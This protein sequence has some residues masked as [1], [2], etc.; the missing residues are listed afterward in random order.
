[1]APISELPARMQ[2]AQPRV[3]EAY[4]FAVANPDA[5]RNVPC[6]CGCVGMGHTDNYACYVQGTNADGTL[7]F[8]EHALN[9][10]V[11]VDISHDVMRLSRE[12]KSPATIRTFIVS[13]YSRFGPPTQ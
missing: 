11:C 9:C 12:G 2:A 6:Y 13:N 10:L 8:D 7:I 1:M 3:R 4:Q 5:L